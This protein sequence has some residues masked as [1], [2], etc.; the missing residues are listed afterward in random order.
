MMAEKARIVEPEETAIT[1]QWLSKHISLATYTHT[2]DEVLKA[3]ISMRS[4]PVLYN[5]DTSCVYRVVR[6]LP[7][8]ND[9]NLEAEEST[10]LGAV[11]RQPV[12]KTSRLRRLSECCSEL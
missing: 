6:Q 3:V 7:A 8:S 9:M 1:R 10:A 5:K 11:A 12:L 2:I 4:V